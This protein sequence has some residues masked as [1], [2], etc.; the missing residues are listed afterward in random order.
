MH[1]GDRKSS[2]KNG[3]LQILKKIDR[4]NFEKSVQQIPSNFWSKLISKLN[5][6][7]L[8]SLHKKAR[9]HAKTH[10]LWSH[11]K[12]ERL[13]FEKSAIQIVILGP[14]NLWGSVLKI[15]PFDFYFNGGDR[16][17]S[18]KNGLST[19]EIKIERLDFEKCAIQRVI[20]GPENLFCSVLKIAWLNF[21]LHGGDR[22]SSPK[23]GLSTTEIKIVWFNF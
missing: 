20:L 5:H 19:V 12:I 1:G 14:E 10:L 11:F 9:V 23:N 8:I 17:S 2:P 13:D 6:T 15:Q 21:F 3:G 22:K 16:K 7:F 4:A 18:P